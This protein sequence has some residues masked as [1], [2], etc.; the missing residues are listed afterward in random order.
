LQIDFGGARGTQPEKLRVRA[1]SFVGIKI[2]GVQKLE[3]C[4]ARWIKAA[5]YHEDAPLKKGNFVT[6]RQR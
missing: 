3:L 1:R 2:A 4:P 6:A 5:I